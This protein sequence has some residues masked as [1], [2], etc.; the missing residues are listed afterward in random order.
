MVN[1]DDIKKNCRGRI[2]INE[3]LSKYTSL[4]VGGPADYF[5]EPANQEDVI[6]IVN[7]LQG[8]HFPMFVIGKGSNLLVSDDGI[9]GAV[10]NLEAGLASLLLEGDAVVAEAGVT[11]ARFVDFTIQQSFKGA[12]MLAG[13]PGTL[14][15]AIMMNAGA[16]GGEISD[17]LV[18]V[19]V[20][21]DGSRMTVKKEAAGFS[22]RRSAFQRDVILRARFRYPAGDKGEVLNARRDMLLKRNK[23]QPLNFPN[24]GSMFKNPTGNFAGRLIEQAGLKGTKRGNAQISEKHG[25]FIINLGDAKAADVV[26]LLRLA[27]TTVSQ[28]FGILL[29]PEVKLVGFPESVTKEFTA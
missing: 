22:Y 14:G 19:D 13:I 18:D 17:F 29:E 23:S 28:K 9:R 8:Q 21:R 1:I 24:S 2:A 25:N 26:D 4:R 27:R 16:W 7:Y 10:M 11:I 12:E 15:G 20:L 5:L 3:P 6:R